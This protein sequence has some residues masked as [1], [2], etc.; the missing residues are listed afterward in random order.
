VKARVKYQTMTVEERRAWVARRTP[1][2]TRANDRAR[3]ARDR[4]KRIAKMTAYNQRDPKRPARIAVSNALRDGRLQ[5]GPCEIGEDCEGP[6]QAHHD[7]YS[8]PLEVRWLCKKHH[9]Q[10]H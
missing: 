9:W 8:K 3:Y 6:V 1:E 4:S 2:I 5:R 10:E 7:D